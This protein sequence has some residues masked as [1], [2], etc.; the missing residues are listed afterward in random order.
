M[1]WINLIL[2]LML[3]ASSLL[4]DE[5]IW[6]PS[7]TFWMGSDERGM[8]DTKPWHQ[9]TVDGFWMDRAPIT[10]IEFSEFVKET[11]YVTTAEKRLDPKQYPG[12]RLQDLEPAGIV[13]VQTEGPVDLTKPLNWWKLI[14]GA[15]WEHPEGPHTNIENLSDH[16]VVHVSYE[17]AQAYAKWKGKRLP[18]EAEWEYAARGGLEKK[19]Y[20]WGDE[21]LPEGKWMAN[22]WQGKFPYDNSAEDGF[23]GTSPVKH[24]P[25]NGYGLYDMSGNVWEWCSDWYDAKYYSV[26]P[27]KNP[28]GPEKS[29]D[30]NE[31]RIAKRVLRGGSFLCC[32]QYCRRYVPGGRGKNSPDS[33][34]SN[35]GFRCVKSHPLPKETPDLHPPVSSF[36]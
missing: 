1:F 3:L 4:A 18:T 27:S 13:F 5:M 8:P 20:V 35:I 21:K 26:S 7:G 23:M 15:S 32:D 16:P 34:T 31:P 33:G 30:P 25:P 19:K 10:N 24:Y 17:D 14:R 9:V 11:G 22:I 29:Y 12:A 2:S 6:I 36:D 28:Q